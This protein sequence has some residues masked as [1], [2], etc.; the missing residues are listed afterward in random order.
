MDAPAQAESAPALTVAICADA[1]GVC[2][3]AIHERGLLSCCDHQFCFECI[4]QWAVTSTNCCPLCRQRFNAIQKISRLSVS[5]PVAVD[6]KDIRDEED[7]DGEDEAEDGDEYSESEQ[8]QRNAIDQFFLAA[9][10]QQSRRTDDYQCDDFLVPDDFVEYE[11]HP[12]PDYDAIIDLMARSDAEPRRRAR[13]RLREDRYARRLR[14]QRER[15]RH[16]GRRRGGRQQPSP[17]VQIRARRGRRRVR[18]D[19]SDDDDETSNGDEPAL[20]TQL[21]LPVSTQSGS[22]A[23]V[24]NK[25]VLGQG[26]TAAGASSPALDRKGAGASL[27]SVPDEAV[28]FSNEIPTQSTPARSGRVP[29]KRTLLTPPS[30]SSA[31]VTSS[32]FAQFAFSGSSDTFGG[33]VVSSPPP[34]ARARRDYVLVAETPEKLL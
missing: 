10:R 33:V 2:L 17:R 23:T 5:A 16:H 9:N 8:A 12:E 25:A 30:P 1:C 13:Q 18:I 15:E 21:P 4:H 7:E 14:R 19:S 27:G 22:R 34:R 28:D 11:T 32:L 24:G 31:S 3:E 20:A 26:V 29:R 6:D